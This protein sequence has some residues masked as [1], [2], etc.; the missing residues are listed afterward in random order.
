MEKYGFIE[1]PIV[2]YDGNEEEITNKQPHDCSLMEVIRKVRAKSIESYRETIP[3]GDFREDNK[4]WT[5]VMME[6]GDAFIVNMP[7]ADF[8]KLLKNHLENL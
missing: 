2:I 6:S 5:E 1:L 8:E 7:L 3:S 4:I